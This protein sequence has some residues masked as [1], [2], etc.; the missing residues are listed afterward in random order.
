MTVG[1]LGYA[2]LTTSNEL[3]YT[4]CYKQAICN[5]IARIVRESERFHTSK[6]N[7]MRTAYYY[8][9]HHFNVFE[10]EARTQAGGP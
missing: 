9:S 8:H 5:E 10:H 6:V 7:A 4:V 1:I 3:L 2:M